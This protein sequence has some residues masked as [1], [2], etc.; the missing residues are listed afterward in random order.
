MHAYILQLEFCGKSFSY[1]R[2][3][4]EKEGKKYE[5]FEDKK[6]TMMIKIRVLSVICPLKMHFSLKVIPQ[7]LKIVSLAASSHNKLENC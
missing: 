7:Y 1:L 3:F 6:K 4:V 2:F 5:S